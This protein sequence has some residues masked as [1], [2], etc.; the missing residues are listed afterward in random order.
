MSLKRKIALSNILMIAVPLFFTAAVWITYIFFHKGQ[1]VSLTDG[2]IGKSRVP[3]DLYNSESSK[4]NWAELSSFEP[5]KAD[6]DFI[7]SPSEQVLN[8]LYDAGFRFSVSIGT[9][10]FFSNLQKKDLPLTRFSKKS[11]NIEENRIVIRD[12]ISQDGTLYSIVA[13]YDEAF[14]DKGVSSSLLPIYLVSPHAMLFF[15]TAVVLVI[16]ALNFLLTRYLSKAATLERQIQ[17]LSEMALLEN[18]EL[19]ATLD[20]QKLVPEGLTV[21]QKANVSEKIRAAEL[22]IIPS[23][24]TVTVKGIPV[25]LK[26]KEFELLLFL[27]QNR[28]IVFSKETL[29]ERVWGDNIAGDISTVTVHIK[30]IREKIEVNPAEPRYIQTIWGA[31]YKFC[32]NS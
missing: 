23:S 21:S 19:V 10:T 5:D 14:A 12:E 3:L 16:V 22:E 7:L 32:S 11:I 20:G 13:V 4:I 31:G 9:A 17:N 24:R 28:D 6:S 8:E 26:N 25:I 2:M 15:L 30:R 1:Y 29:Y 18:A 27:V